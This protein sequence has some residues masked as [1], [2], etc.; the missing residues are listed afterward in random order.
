MHSIK[1]RFVIGPS[2]VL[3][4]VCAFQPG[5]FTGRGSEGVKEFT[6]NNNIYLEELEYRKHHV[7]LTDSSL[8]TF[9]LDCGNV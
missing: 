8:P 5:N 7:F 2:N 9:S 1:S 4:A 6:K 3:F